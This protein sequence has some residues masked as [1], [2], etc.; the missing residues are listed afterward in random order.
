MASFN[1]AGHCIKK[2]GRMLRRFMH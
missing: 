2:A 1:K